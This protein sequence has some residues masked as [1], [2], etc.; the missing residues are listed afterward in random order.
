RVKNTANIE[1][2]WNTETVEIV[3]NEQTGVTGAH[4]RNVLTHEVYDI[5]VT[6]FFVAIG[7]QPNTRIFAEWLEM[8][9]NGYI[10]TVPGT[11][12]T[13]VEGVFACGDAQDH[14]YRQ[15]VTAAGTGCMAALD[16]ERWLAAV[17]A[18]ANV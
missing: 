8:D 4:L 3:G 17:E 15:A 14:V 9:T 11:T 13:N 5:P 18:N 1:I 10:K 6:G 12:H 16:A 7:H 2:L